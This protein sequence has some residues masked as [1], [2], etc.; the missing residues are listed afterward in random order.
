ME[1]QTG[2]SS[3]SKNLTAKFGSFI[4]RIFKFYNRE[5]FFIKGNVNNVVIVALIFISFVTQLTVSLY[6]YGL[7]KNVDS[8]CS[9]VIDHSMMDSYPLSS[10]STSSSKN[11][12]R[13]KITSDNSGTTSDHDVRDYFIK[14]VKRASTSV[15]DNTVSSNSD[16]PHAEFFDPKLRPE[17]EMKDKMSNG[18]GTK[19]P[20]EDSSTNPWVWLTSYSRIPVSLIFCASMCEVYSVI[21]ISL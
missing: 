16:E 2:E 9:F 13:S 17:L 5:V 7:I 1:T 18:N 19:K 14:R 11:S 20:G 12:Y 6:L 8:R 21:Q 4:K 3:K 10:L 15:I